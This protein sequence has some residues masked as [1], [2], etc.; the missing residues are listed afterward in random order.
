MLSDLAENMNIMRKENFSKM[1]LI[2]LKNTFK[3][4]DSLH[5]VDSR[6]PYRKGQSE[7]VARKYPN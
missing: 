1:E 7:A 4:T 5:E 6:L 3:V 2:K